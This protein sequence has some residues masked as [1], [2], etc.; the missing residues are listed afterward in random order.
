MSM[1]AVLARRWKDWRIPP[2]FYPGFRP[3]WFD[4][5]ITMF[6]AFF[7]AVYILV[8]CWNGRQFDLAKS[9]VP[10]IL[11]G[12]PIL[13]MVFLILYKFTWYPLCILARLSLQGLIFQALLFLLMIAGT[14]VYQASVHRT[15]YNSRELVR[16]LED[17]RERNNTYPESLEILEKARKEP[18]PIPTIPQRDRRGF[19][20][21]SHD[22]YYT[23]SFSGD[24]LDWWDYDSR[25]G[26]WSKGDAARAIEI[27]FTPFFIKRE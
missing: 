3:R 22:D 13:L 23:L 6:F 4:F 12:S 27:L 10:L 8:A 5:A 19:N 11:Y 14:L 18:L 2:F 7:A 9:L 16:A 20:Y 17:Y 26:T 1:I 24:F 21:H 25:K 15:F